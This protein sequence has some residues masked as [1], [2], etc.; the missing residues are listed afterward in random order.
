[1]ALREIGD[2]IAF[3]QRGTGFSKPNLTCLDRLALPLDV[4][5]TREAAIKE[6]R[7]KL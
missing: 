3:D 2:V 7:S 1:M 5:P 6:L 4:P